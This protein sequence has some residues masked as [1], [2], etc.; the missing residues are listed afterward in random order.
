MVI[1]PAYKLL[2]NIEFKARVKLISLFISVISMVD[3]YFKIG[4]IKYYR[5]SLLQILES[6]NI[7]FTNIWVIKV[8]FKLSYKVLIISFKIR[9]V[10]LQDGVCL[11]F[12]MFF[13]ISYIYC[14]NFLLFNIV[15]V[16]LYNKI[17]TIVNLEMS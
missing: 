5:Y 6:I 13:Y 7:L 15:A 4:S 2:F 10:F 11:R 9:S 8:S 14:S 12:S 3:N 17:I 16:R 1:K